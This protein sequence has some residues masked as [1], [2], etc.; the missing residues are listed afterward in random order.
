MKKSFI[1]FCFCFI[2]IGLQAQ[3][4]H[5]VDVRVREANTP[6]YK[7]ESSYEPLPSDLMMVAARSGVNRF[8]EYSKMA[9]DAL[10]KGDK[11][12]FI[13][14]TNYALLTDF[15]SAKMYYDRG[16]VFQDLGDYK[17]AKKNYKK[18]KKHGYY[19]AN[20][21]LVELKELTKKKK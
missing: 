1:I 4:T 2:A 12:G 17:Q 14:Y 10:N 18:A 19:Q 5:Y 13:T 16:K 8:N 15:Y 11:Y 9:Y 6:N 20:Q 7:V 3:N 21:A